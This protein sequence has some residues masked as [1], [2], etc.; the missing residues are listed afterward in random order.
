MPGT[1]REYFLDLLASVVFVEIL[2]A[3]SSARA[4]HRRKR[5]SETFSAV[6]GV[7]L[8]DEWSEQLGRNAGVL[9]MCGCG[10][11]R[12]CLDAFSRRIA[13]EADGERGG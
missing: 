13:E 3:M 1:S 10:V 7:D 12:R 5:V 11:P 6:S 8:V 9:K 4:A 2:R